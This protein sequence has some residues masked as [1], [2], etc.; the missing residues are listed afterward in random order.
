MLLVVLYIWSSM[1]CCSVLAQNEPKC[2]TKG[3]SCT[4]DTD[5]VLMS[6]VT[7]TGQGRGKL[8]ISASVKCADTASDCTLK[9]AEYA[10]VEIKSKIKVGTFDVTS[11]T[12]INVGAD[13]DTT[14]TSKD[15]AALIAGAGYGE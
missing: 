6:S 8:V 13:I 14:A 7:W 10:D 9:I 1:F 2:D 3:D 15:V 11:S 12:S 5:A 4:I